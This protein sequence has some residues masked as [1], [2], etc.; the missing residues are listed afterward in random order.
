MLLRAIRNYNWGSETPDRGMNNIDRWGEGWD[1]DRLVSRLLATVR[2]ASLDIYI[3][4]K[5]ETEYA[6]LIFPRAPGSDYRFEAHIYKGLG[7]LQ[8]HAELGDL[9]DEEQIYF[10][11]RSYERWD[12]TGLEE[13][14]TQFE[15]DLLL[16]LTYD[17]RV[18]Q[19]RGL[20]FWHFALQYH[21]DGWQELAGASAFRWSRINVPR[22]ERREKTWQASALPSHCEPGAQG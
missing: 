9:D 1:L 22:I 3:R 17:T 7:D 8:I 16:V 5:E 2:A 18:K 10:W 15:R 11:Y 12:F 14:L 21:K 19:R 20:A 6:R 13:M 4:V